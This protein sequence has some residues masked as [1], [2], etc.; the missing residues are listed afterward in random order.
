MPTVPPIRLVSTMIHELPR[1]RAGD[2]SDPVVLS[3]APTALDP[4]TD[5][6]IREEMLQPS[7]VKGR[8]IVFGADVGSPVP[9][10][11]RA[12]LLDHSQLERASQEM[13]QHLYA[14]QW[15]SASAGVF[16]CSLAQADSIDR[17]VIMKAEHQ[18][19]VRLRQTTRDDGTIEFAVE[20]LNELIL[21]RAAQVYK[22]ALIWIDPASDRLV[23]LMVD[24]QNGHGYADY[25]LSGYLGFELVHQ[26]EVLTQEFVRA[27]SKFLNSNSLGA[28]KKIRYGGAVAAVL[29]SP[30]PNL[31][32]GDFIRDFIDREDRDELRALMP[33]QVAGFEFRKDVTLVSNMI[34]GL[35]VS[36]DNGVTV[37]A[38]SGAIEAGTIEV[39]E[40]RIVI[41]GDPVSYNLSKPPR[42]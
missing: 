20:H 7:F 11:A 28:E 36:T 27:V 15:G 3:S 9:A 41:N 10:L 42:D 26:A 29:E 25:F 13:A 19:G 39:E 37:Q 21:G 35:K 40:H 30:R 5:R 22:I 31:N 2:G 23:G 12:A 8:E 38:S 14:T 34:G 1:G 32:P 18:E 6:F 17:L 16:L 33:T 24:R 4:R